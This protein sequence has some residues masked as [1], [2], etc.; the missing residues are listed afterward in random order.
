VYLLDEPTRG[1]DVGARQAILQIIREEVA[2]EAGVI[3]TSPGVDDLLAVCDRIAIMGHGRVV[4]IVERAAFDET[5]LYVAV[6]S[7]AAVRTGQTERG[8]EE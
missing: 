7:A 3:M 2:A 6:Q 1:V 5:S 8:M 4:G